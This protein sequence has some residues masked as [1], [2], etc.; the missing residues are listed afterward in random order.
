MFNF[1]K[2]VSHKAKGKSPKLVSCCHDYSVFFCIDWCP[3]NTGYF[4]LFFLSPLPLMEKSVIFLGQE[5]YTQSNQCSWNHSEI[6]NGEVITLIHRSASM[7]WAMNMLTVKVSLLWRKRYWLVY[8]TTAN[9]CVDLKH[10]CNILLLKAKWRNMMKR[11]EKTMFKNVSFPT[12]ST[13]CRTSSGIDEGYTVEG[14]L[15]F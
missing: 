15:S 6:L 2:H 14:K 7:R 8:K 10:W 9:W 12:T 3:S 5:L 13:F 11:N 4:S 1:T